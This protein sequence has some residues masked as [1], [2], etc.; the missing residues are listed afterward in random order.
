M[1]GDLYESR[2]TLNE[3]DK[4]KALEAIKNFLIV[5]LLKDRVDPKVMVGD[6]GILEGTIRRR[7]QMK[8]IKK[9]EKVK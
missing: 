1:L 2:R 9:S 6:M 4:A 5:S 8:F 7:F 3:K